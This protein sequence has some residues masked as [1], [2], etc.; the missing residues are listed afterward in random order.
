[1]AQIAPQH[2]HEREVPIGIRLQIHNVHGERSYDPI[3][4]VSTWT[5]ILSTMF[6]AAA[7]AM[8]RIPAS[9]NHALRLILLLSSYI[10]ISTFHPRT[11]SLVEASSWTQMGNDIDGED[12][13]DESG[14]AV[15]ISSDGSR[16]AI[17][18]RSNTNAEFRGGH[19]RV[20]DIVGSIWVP[21]GADLDAEAAGDLMGSAVAMSGNGS[22]VAIGA[23][24]NDEAVV[25]MTLAAFNAALEDGRA[26]INAMRL[27]PAVGHWLS[28]IDGMVYC[29]VASVFV[30]LQCFHF[31]NASSANVLVRTSSPSM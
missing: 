24:G 12:A 13:Y 29:N 25:T 30:V 14:Y 2:P 11:S 20:F 23:T 19:V 7:N 10:A 15:A 31:G 17:G 5:M 18:A 16:V 6:Y 27:F 26:H 9:T 22:R 28:L 1:V 4:R 21:A 3:T 8:I